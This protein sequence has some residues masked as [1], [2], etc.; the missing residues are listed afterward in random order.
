[1]REVEGVKELPDFRADHLALVVLNNSL[2]L[3]VCRGSPLGEVEAGDEGV[4]LGLSGSF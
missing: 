3:F 2:W 1:M 4:D